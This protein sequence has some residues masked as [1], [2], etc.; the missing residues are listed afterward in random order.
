MES[1]ASRVV[2]VDTLTLWR[3]VVWVRNWRKICSFNSDTV[4]DGHLSPALKDTG[5]LQ[6]SA[7]VEDGGLGPALKEDLQLRKNRVKLKVSK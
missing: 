5:L 1:A 2:S 7:A 4:E 3:T 6:H